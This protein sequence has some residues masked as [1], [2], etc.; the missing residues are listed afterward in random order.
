MVRNPTSWTTLASM[1][2]VE[3]PAGV[4]FS[5][6]SDDSELTT[7]DYQ[8]SVDFV[9]TIREFFQ[10]YPERKGNTMYIASESYGG[11]YIPQLA[12]LLLEDDELSEMFSGILLG[13]LHPCAIISLRL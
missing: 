11:H 8:A 2:F 3:Q 10:Q 1:V 12:L 6:T 5:K 13:K 9:S 4:G 7:N